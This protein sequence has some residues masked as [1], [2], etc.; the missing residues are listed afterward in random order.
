MEITSLIGLLG[1][2][3][4]LGFFG[5]NEISQKIDDLQNLIKQNDEQAENRVKNVEKIAADANRKAQGLIDKDQH[6]ATKID[7]ENLSERLKAVEEEQDGKSISELESKISTLQ[8]RSENFQKSLQT[9]QSKNYDETISSLIA[10]VKNIA[11]H[12]NSMVE[13]LKTFDDNLQLLD[14]GIKNLDAKYNTLDEELK[15]VEGQIQGVEN[16]VHTVEN[17]VQTVEDRPLRFLRNEATP[18]TLVKELLT[19][20]G[21][22]PNVLLKLAS[23]N[24]ASSEDNYVPL[25]YV[26]ARY[27]KDPEIIKTLLGMGADFHVNNDHALIL[28]AISRNANSPELIVQALIDVGLN[29]NT[30]G[31][32]RDIPLCNNIDGNTALIEA[33]NNHSDSSGKILQ[34]LVNA[35]ANVN[36]K[37]KKG[38]TALMKAVVVN[39]FNN[40]KKKAE[41]LIKA[42]A[43]LN[44]QDNSGETALHK[45]AY[46]MD[47]ELF[48]MLVE[49]GA[50]ESITNKSGSTAS[51]IYDLFASMHR[52]S[53]RA[54]AKQIGT[55]RETS[56]ASK[57]FAEAC[58]SG[59]PQS[60]MKFLEEKK[61]SPNAMLGNEPLLSVAVGHADSADVVRALLN[62]GADP[63]ISSDTGETPLFVAV[64]CADTRKIKILLEAGAD[65]NARTKDGKTALIHYLL[66]KD[67]FVIM[68][69]VVASLLEGGTD[70]NARMNDGT[71]ALIVA[72]G[73]NQGFSQ[74]PK[75]IKMLISADADINA[76]DKDGLTPLINAAG[77]RGE[78]LKTNEAI[79]MLINA[80]ADVNAR[81]KDDTTALARAAQQRLAD[82][83]I[84]LLK[85]GADVNAASK[86]L[87]EGKTLLL[88]AAESAGEPEVVIPELLKAN[89]DTNY[90]DEKGNT[91]ALLALLK[92][93]LSLAAEDP[94]N[95]DVRTVGIV[96]TMIRGG[97]DVN[98]QDYR[99]KTPI[100][101]AAEPKY[102]GGEHVFIRTILTLLSAGADPLMK[103]K[104]GN[105]AKINTKE[106]TREL[107]RNIGLA[108]MGKS[109]IPVNSTL[110]KGA[111]KLGFDINTKYD[112]KFSPS[113]DGDT[114]LYIIALAN[115]QDDIPE[116]LQVQLMQTLI[117]GGADVNI[118]C[119]N[120]KLTAVFP[121]AINNR[122]EVIA[123]LAKNSANL[124]AKDDYPDGETALFYAIRAG[125]ERA[126]T[127]LL[128]NGTNPNTRNK[129]GITPL[130]VASAI[131]SNPEIIREL[132]NAGADPLASYNGMTVLDY[133][134]IND[135]LRNTNAEDILRS[136]MNS[137]NIIAKKET[138]KVQSNPNWDQADMLVGLG[139]IPMYVKYALKEAGLI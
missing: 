4:L 87:P 65:A 79:S 109:E 113:D 132:I 5:R 129:N 89:T 74:L 95:A 130:I 77:I 28:A 71:T 60:V 128:D 23:E 96:Q 14:T 54:V 112:T 120:D 21:L 20:K 44:I 12:F 106:L 52:K 43:D 31:E 97:A 103:S 91:A 125:A 26:A 34:V 108:A 99:G 122:S 116:N 101:Y 40:P 7:T 110:I 32:D 25:V 134:S 90:R 35:G 118:T 86:N 82:N 139:K 30:T 50:D 46:G 94:D 100:I 27:A 39:G 41:I 98:A 64:E 10:D 13:G 76:K 24:V 38:E 69:E 53:L 137:A 1:L 131:V 136:A 17:R 67:G 15:T 22:S 73:K 61:L 55:Y 42:G 78:N 123:L 37:N 85:A 57:E 2:V 49:A 33:A 80:G 117:E 107:N 51:D 58:E 16:Q 138:K 111:A 93:G 72:T 119:T 6:F 48:D 124:E 63:N 29:V 56:N 59:S 88:I 135:K 102:I 105:T 47:Q 19:E 68:E 70:V 92:H 62:A 84:P 126:I 9:I 81:M 104:D 121:P 36:A 114:L 133:L 115:D 83:F 127:A 3:G 8:K 45:A 75:V 66:V 11:D 18:A